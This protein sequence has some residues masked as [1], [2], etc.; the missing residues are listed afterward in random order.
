MSG[1]NLGDN[2]SRVVKMAM[3]SGEVTSI[4]EAKHLF[5]N[6][7][8]VIEVG[9]DVITSPSLQTALLTAVNTG[10]RCFLGG[11]QVVGKVDVGLRI[12]WR[13]YQTL[14]DAIIDLQGKIVNSPA[15][16]VPRVVIGDVSQAQNS[17][18]FA[19]QVTFN[20]WSG[21]VIPVEDGRRLPEQD[22]FTPSGIL[23]GALAVSEAFQ[24]LRGN[25]LAGRRDV[26][27]S[28]WKPETGVSWLNTDP[29]PTLELLPTKLWLIGLGHLGQAFLWTL[30]LLPYA[31]PEEMRLVLQDCDTLVPA[32]DSTSLLTS[33]PILGLKK[34]RAMA[35]WCEERGFQTVILERQ[36]T[37][38]FLIKDDEP[39]VALCG[40]D[41]M[42][43][44]AALEDVGFSRVIEVGLGQGPNEYLAFQ[45]H[46]FP[47][48]R[49]ART[50]WGGTEQPS[51]PDILVS[52]PAYQALAAEGV[53]QCGLTMLAGR[54]VGAPFV[55]ATTAAIAIAELLRMVIGEHRYEVIDGTL[56]SLTH[57]QAI[58]SDAGFPP[59]NPGFTRVKMG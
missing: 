59:F 21:G 49:S 51:E 55:G 38:N 46:T 57:R 30:G 34:T 6:Y 53:D 54:T 43:A 20:G 39:Q 12:P 52:Q 19:V 16:K 23:A 47:A 33:Q 9:P 4:I 14:A 45:V 3:D 29:G 31:H 36:F 13:H 56:H 10:R 26:G 11:V 35:G 1:S 5:D 22:E 17:S 2:L 18:E 40:V 50:R 28:L 7:Q 15:P 27:L 25:A 8:L 32:N 42:P 37:N 44:R 24:F 41:N 58:V 48:Q